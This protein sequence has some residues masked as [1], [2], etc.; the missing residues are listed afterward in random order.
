MLTT[1]EDEREIARCYAL[2]CNL[3]LPKPMDYENFC[4]AVHELG[5]FIQKAKFP[6][7]TVLVA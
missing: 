4:E 7:P 6:G 1:A 5:L 2:G 3:Y